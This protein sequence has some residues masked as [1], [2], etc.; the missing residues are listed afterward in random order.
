MA[1]VAGLLPFSL[2]HACVFAPGCVV[3]PFQMFHAGLRQMSLH[4]DSHTATE[5]SFTALLVTSV[6]QMHRLVAISIAENSYIIHTLAV[7]NIEC[8]LYNRCNP[9]GQ[10]K[11]PEGNYSHARRCVLWQ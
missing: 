4:A 11:R 10:W 8:Q 1:H 9:K 6:T 2:A 3:M 5:P 7:T